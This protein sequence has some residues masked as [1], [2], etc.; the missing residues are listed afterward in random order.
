MSNQ[1]P[2]YGLDLTAET[3]GPRINRTTD[4]IL[5]IGLS[6]TAEDEIYEGGEPE[7]IELLDRRLRLLP[8][9]VIA[10]WHGSILAIPLIVA[11]AERWDLT[12]GLRVEIDRRAA[13]LSPIL[14][15]ESAVIGQWHQHQLLDLR[16]IYETSEP[17]RW[18]RLGRSKSNA[19]DLIPPVDDLARRDPRKDAR[20]A[21]QLAERR[22]PQARRFVDRVEKLSGTEASDVGQSAVTGQEASR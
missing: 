11:R 10:S 7:L 19:E 21:R 2:I 14:G 5:K 3:A 13:P 9:G 1:P 22:W 16:R 6:R 8:V 12:L 20:L 4:R 18:S 17:R 15:V